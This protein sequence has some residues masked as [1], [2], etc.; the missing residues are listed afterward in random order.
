MPSK[1]GS[2]DKTLP[3][4]HFADGD[5]ELPDPARRRCLGG[6]FKKLST[7][8]TLLATGWFAVRPA[9][10]PIQS[11]LSESYLR[12]IVSFSIGSLVATLTDC[13]N[14]IVERSL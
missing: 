11:W 5:L 4:S 10:P 3:T 1:D 6:R 7:C 13:P 8:V 9:G 12:L 2:L 14:R